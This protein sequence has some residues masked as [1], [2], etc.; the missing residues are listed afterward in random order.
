VTAPDAAPG[1]PPG[2]APYEAILEHAELELELA[3]RGEL[4]RL[5]ELGERWDE[6]LRAVP[7]LPP[8][9][10]GPLLS[11]ASLIHQRTHIELLR[12]RELLLTDLATAGRATRTV[13]GYSGQLRRR[14]HLDRSA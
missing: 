6:L 12:M 13:A 5:Q 2:L 11:R 7:E 8:A 4:D 1:V 9:A 14:P 3:G 10:A